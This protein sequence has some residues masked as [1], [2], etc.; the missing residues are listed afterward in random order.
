MEYCKGDTAALWKYS[1]ADPQNILNK[2][3]TM[4]CVCRESV[5]SN[6]TVDQ[7]NYNVLSFS[8]DI[9]DDRP[10]SYIEALEKVISVKNPQLIMCIV[11]NNRVDRY[12]AIKKYCCLNRAGELCAVLLQ[13]CL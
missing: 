3:F 6:I 5:F 12:S 7:I 9:Q 10:S 8:F 4:A 13:V 2:V 11:Q 1:C